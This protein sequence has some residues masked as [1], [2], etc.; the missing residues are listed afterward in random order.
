MLRSLVGSEMCIRDSINGEEL[1]GASIHDLLVKEGKPELANELRAAF[2]ASMASAS[3]I[4][5]NAKLGVS[6]D[7]QI[8]NE[9]RKKEVYATISA[10]ATQTDLIQKAIDELGVSAEDLKQDT[11]EDI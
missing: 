11:E 4:D 3:V 7:V 9:D 5:T 8:Q 1:V 6:F 10:L 2:E